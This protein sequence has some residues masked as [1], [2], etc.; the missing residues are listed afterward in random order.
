MKKRDL[1]IPWQCSSPVLMVGG[2]EVDP[3]QLKSLGEKLPIVATDS[4]ADIVAKAGFRPYLV[5]GDFDSISSVESFSDSHIIETPSQDRTDFSKTLGL[6]ESPLVIGLGFLG[7]R[8]DHSLASINSLARAYPQAVLLMDKHDV[9]FF[10]RKSVALNL[11]GGGDR[12]RVSLFP[13]GAQGFVSSKG[14]KWSLSGLEMDSIEQIGTSNQV[15]AK[16][17]KIE[18]TPADKGEGY[19]VIL[20]AKNFLAAAEFLAPNYVSQLSP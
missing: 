18:I 5:A 15:S 6:V 9:V 2:G 13:M 3:Q 12:D 1:D 10:T 17:G 8:F 19:L 7:R 4:G 14:L 16:D 11:S 20:E